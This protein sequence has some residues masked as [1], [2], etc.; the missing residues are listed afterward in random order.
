MAMNEKAKGNECYKAGE[1]EEAMVFYSR[2]LACLDDR[3]E[4][5]P[6]CWANRAMAALK[7]GLLEK[8]GD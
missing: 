1:P 4:E 6:K 3:H 5:T 2:A 8:A 7:L